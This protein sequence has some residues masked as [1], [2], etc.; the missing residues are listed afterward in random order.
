MIAFYVIMCLCKVRPI[1]CTQFGARMDDVSMLMWL[2]GQI[3]V[4]A[5]IWGGIRADLKNIHHTQGI[6][7]QDI[8]ESRTRIDRLFELYYQRNSNN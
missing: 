6:H 7:Q 3:I 4:G 8:K 1:L 5:A 2:G